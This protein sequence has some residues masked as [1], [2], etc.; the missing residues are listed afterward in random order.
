MK[1]EKQSFTSNTSGNDGD[2]QCI[3]VGRFV[4]NSK[5]CLL[6][7]ND[8]VLTDRV[9]SLWWGGDGERDASVVVVAIALD[10]LKFGSEVA[11]KTSL[12]VLVSGF[13]GGMG[14]GLGVGGFVVGLGVG[15]LGVGLGVGGF[16][17]GFGVGAG[18]KPGGLGVGL[19]VGVGFG[20]E[21]GVGFGAGVY[22]RTC[23][24]SH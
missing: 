1:L 17:V 7:N 23:E 9:R 2:Q 15:G 12:D 22:A 3:V 11:F 21:M 8:S 18:A 16:G 6:I 5:C 14:V 19:G 20:V 13:G 4:I 10:E 24:N